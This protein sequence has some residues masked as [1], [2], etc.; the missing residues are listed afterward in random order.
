MVSLEGPEEHLL[1]HAEAN[2]LT[3]LGAWCEAPFSDSDK[4]R[5]VE[6]GPSRLQDLSGVNLA[7]RIDDQQHRHA[8]RAKLALRLGQDG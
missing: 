8:P 5:L 6:L 4:R 3:S 1:K 2:R 7:I